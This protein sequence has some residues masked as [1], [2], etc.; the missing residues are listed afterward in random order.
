MPET[1]ERK[2]ASMRQKKS[3]PTYSSVTS[4]TIGLAFLSAVIS[5]GV[6]LF[7]FLISSLKRQYWMAH[8]VGRMMRTR[9]PLY[10]M[11]SVNAKPRREPITT[12]GGSPTRVIV[13]PMVA[14]RVCVR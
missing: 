7:A 11:K 3:E 12:L 2:R 6:I 13:P 4:S 10:L 9:T 1:G 8:D 14:V 5:S